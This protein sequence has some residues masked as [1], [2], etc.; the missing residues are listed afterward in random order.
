MQMSWGSGGMLPVLLVC[1]DWWVHSRLTS[2]SPWRERARPSKWNNSVT[3]EQQCVQLP[4]I[5]KQ[6]LQSENCL[7]TKISKVHE[8]YFLPDFAFQCRECTLGLQ[9]SKYRQFQIKL[10]I[11]IS[12]NALKIKIC[13]VLT[14]L[15]FSNSYF[16]SSHFKTDMGNLENPYHF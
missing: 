5:C 14:D 16:H 8:Q 7:C 6:K 12:V 1:G 10:T 11:K 9:A 2:P 15:L 4:S 3:V 13:A